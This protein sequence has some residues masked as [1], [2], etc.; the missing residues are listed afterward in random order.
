AFYDALRAGRRVA[1]CAAVARSL[2][3]YHAEKSAAVAA[4]L[5]LLWEAARE[6]SRAAEAFGHAAQNALHA[7]APREALDLA[8][9][10]LGM[11]DRL[12]ASPERAHQEL[13]LQLTLSAPVVMTRGWAATE[14]GATYA[15][16]CEL[17]EQVGDHGPR[18]AAL[19][20]LSVFHFCRAQYSQARRLG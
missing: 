14:V 5:A 6:W 1:L 16:I 7:F 17:C 12:P 9:R 15:R 3:H 10:G 11:L 4:E 2:S 18:F 19:R 13:R 20:G 8:Q